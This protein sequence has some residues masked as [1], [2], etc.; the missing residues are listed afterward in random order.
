MLICLPLCQEWAN[1]W[2]GYTDIRGLG[3][4]SGSLCHWGPA[5]LYLEGAHPCGLGCW[6]LGAAPSVFPAVP[7]MAPCGRFTFS[8][9]LNAATGPS[10][11]CKLS[12]DL[13]AVAGARRGPVCAGLCFP[14]PDSWKQCFS[15]GLAVSP[16]C[17]L[18]S[19][20]P[21]LLQRY[22]TCILPPAFSRDGLS[23]FAL[24]PLL[25]V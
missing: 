5:G 4:G 6:P 1:S 9:L 18:R 7:A 14:H 20:V 25:H 17:I 19:Q 10:Q 21:F 13:S 24:T 11:A 23:T 22:S 12:A 8:G 3:E 2:G 15:T 16:G